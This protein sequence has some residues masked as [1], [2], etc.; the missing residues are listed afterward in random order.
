MTVLRGTDSDNYDGDIPTAH[1]QKL[2]DQY[3][4]RFNI[5][6]LE[7][8]MP[9]AAAQRDRALQ[10][11]IDTPFAYKLLYWTQNDL[12]RLKAAAGFGK[13]I[14]LDCEWQQGMQQGWGA[15]IERIHQAKDLLMAEGLYWGIYT[16]SWWWVPNTGNC[17]DFKGDHL[18]NA[19][20][21]FGDGVVP[22]VD[23]LPSDFTVD[24]GGWTKAEVYQ[25]ADACYEDGPWHLDLNAYEEPVP[26]PFEPATIFINEVDGRQR[27][28][29]EQPG[30]GPG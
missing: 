16:G 30:Y 25:Y 7:A 21:S 2:H 24:Y 17:L 20:Y 13:T 12:E 11:G 26:P 14:A 23:W 3:G 10:A 5:V 9:F 8:G 22:P 1:W 15:T 4:V 19:H 29:V 28:F 27:V 6:G 18:W